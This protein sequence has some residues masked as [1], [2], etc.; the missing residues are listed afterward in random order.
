MKKTLLLFTIISTFIFADIKTI[1]VSE[2]YI[3]KH[4]F[5]IIDIRSIEEVSQFG[6][7]STSIHIPLLDSNGD[8]HILIFEEKLLK[9]LSSK[10]ETFYL[11]DHDGS[12]SMLLSTELFNHGFKNIIVLNGG[13][14]KLHVEGFSI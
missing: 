1:L 7:L 6:N 4:P 10:E 3:E 8:S 2:K 13:T 5:K 14:N 11:I 12:L 9:H